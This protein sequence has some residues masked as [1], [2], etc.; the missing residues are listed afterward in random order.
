MSYVDMS[1]KAW[2]HVW[3]NDEDEYQRH[4]A[5]YYS[6]VMKCY[7]WKNEKWLDQCEVVKPEVALSKFG[8]AGTHCPLLI[9]SKVSFVRGGGDVLI[10]E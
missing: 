2:Y 9:G 7:A 1:L 10:S 5:R 8:P 3:D 4:K 6:M